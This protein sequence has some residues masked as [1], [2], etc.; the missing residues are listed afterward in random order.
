MTE[1]L[2][3]GFKTSSREFLLGVWIYNTRFGVSSVFFGIDIRRVDRKV[4]C[5]SHHCQIFRA[6]AFKLGNCIPPMRFTW[7]IAVVLSIR[8]SIAQL[9]RRL[10]GLE[11][12][13]LS[14]KNIAN[15]S[16]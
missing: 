12:K 8:N 14:P 16:K 7:L 13:L 9:V 15:S 6:I 3:D 5:V 10:V 1:M 2:N 11:A 4:I